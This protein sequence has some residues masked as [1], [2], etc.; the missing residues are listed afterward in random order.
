MSADVTLTSER[1]A[2]AMKP[3]PLPASRRAYAALFVTIGFGLCALPS[4]VSGY[5]MTLAVEVMIA[6]I[7]ASGINLLT[8]YTGLV[9]LG[10]AMFLGFGGY[11][12]AIGT[13]LLGWPLWISAPVTLVVVAAIAAPI[14]AICTRTRGV[15]FLLI[16]L[17]FSQMFYGAA[18]KLRWTNGS[19]GMTGIPRPDLS[20]LGMSADNP[21]VFYYYVLV[22]AVLSLL[23]LWRIVTSPFGS[24]L[25]GI[26][27]NER[28]MMS[29]GYAVANYKV[30]SFA[31]AAVICAVAGILQ[32]QYTYFVNPDAMSWQMS[33][34]GVLM[35]IIGGANVILGP[36]VGAAVFVVVK[37]ALSMITEEYNLFFGIFFMLVV[38]FFRGGV[39]GSISAL[40]GKR[41]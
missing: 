37:Q 31:L 34:E 33:G 27:E 8:G 35:V 12:I 25:V 1:R 9:S 16:T 18:I 15:E 17:A 30:G 19:D 32:S 6:G 41:Q 39:L 4:F 38:A 36:F 22:V 11:G 28:R 13:A 2:G 10:Q 3:L 20:L 23:M 26:R 21:T 7:F 40:I 24:V 14:G 29:M 5:V